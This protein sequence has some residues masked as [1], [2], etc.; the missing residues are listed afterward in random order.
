ME[1]TSL[2]N[3]SSLVEKKDG[4]HLIFQLEE[5]G[6]GI[7]ILTVNEIIGIMAITLIPRAPSFI[8][9][10]INLR[11]KIIPVMDLRLK[12]GMPEKEHTEETCIIIVNIRFENT[13]RQIGIVVDIVSEVV[14]IHETEIEPPPKYSTHDDENFLNGIG[15][16]KDKVVMLLDIEKVI[17]TEEIIKLLEEKK[18]ITKTTGKGV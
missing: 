14:D 18:E 6:Y 4:K 17:Y 12:F 11:G 5:R 13:T 9:G 8:K 15:K 7:P 10:I 3:N 16:V 1:A 2:L